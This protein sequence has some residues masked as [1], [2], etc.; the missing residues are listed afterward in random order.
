MCCDSIIPKTLLLNDHVNF[1]W[2]GLAPSRS[3]WASAAEQSP[4][5]SWGQDTSGRLLS[6]HCS[7][8]PPPESEQ[9]KAA[10]PQK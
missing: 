5:R 8:L 2:G 9:V 3:L 6:E 1:F 7:V 4:K 10:V